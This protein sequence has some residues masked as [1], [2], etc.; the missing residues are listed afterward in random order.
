[1]SLRVVPFFL[2]PFLPPLLLGAPALKE[3]FDPYSDAWPG[4]GARTEQRVAAFAQA[5]E[6][7]SPAAVM[8]ALRG[9]G[10]A[11]EKLQAD[12]DAC[13]RPY[14]KASEKFFGWRR[15]YERDH[16]RKHGVMPGEYPVPPGLQQGFIAC[17]KELKRLLALKRAEYAFLDRVETTLVE[18]WT[19]LPFDST[20]S[21]Q[22]IRAVSSGVSDRDPYFAVLCADLLGRFGFN[23]HSAEDLD[24]ALRRERDPAVLAA[25]YEARGR[26][27]DDEADDHLREGLRHEAWPVRAGA[28]RGLVHMRS[29]ESVDA[30]VEYL[31][32]AEGR[33]VDD[34]ASALAALTGRAPSADAEAWKLWWGAARTSWIA[35]DAVPDGPRVVVSDGAPQPLGVP[36]RSLRV[37]FVLDG[38]EPAALDAMRAAAGKALDELPEAAAFGLVVY[39]HEV[40]TFRK[41]LAE[42]NGTNRVAARE[43]LARY[44]FEPGPQ[45]GQ[46]DLLAGMQAAFALAGNGRGAP[47][48]D[49]IL[50]QVWREPSSGWCLDPLLLASEVNRI[51]RPLGIRL[52]LLGPSP[53]RHSQ[54]LQRMAAPCGGLW[55]GSE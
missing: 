47:E 4:A 27:R 35:P 10:K 7:D 29:T 44:R 34:T 14:L 48:A 39:A 18:R 24:D 42:N 33:L 19:T 1:M 31:A 16:L 5:L 9:S 51:N 41:A 6:E 17:E 30:L 53:A 11:L 15:A 20:A 38:S 21:D 3:I 8:K 37:V 46:A 40:A 12:L 52:H 2:L 55:I 32:Q 54:Y 26:V 50:A 13:Y 23:A 25:L 45:E 22:A 43:W 28:I 49:T 36:T